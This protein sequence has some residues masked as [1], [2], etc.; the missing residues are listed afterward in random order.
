M[1]QGTKGEMQEAM[2]RTPIATAIFA[3]L[4]LWACLNC[5][6][7]QSAPSDEV[8]TWVARNCGEVTEEAFASRR[9]D[10]EV[11]TTEAPLVELLVGGEFTP[12]KLVLIGTLPE[13]LRAISIESPAKPLCEQLIDLK[14]SNQSLT[15]EQA[16]SLVQLKVK[17]HALAK[18]P[19]LKALYRS[20]SQLEASL[21]P[22]DNIYFPG[23]SVILSV[24]STHEKVHIEFTAPDPAADSSAYSGYPEASQPEI[25]EWALAVLEALE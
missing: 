21:K 10:F 8:L 12:E 7:A 1:V 4:G 5:F 11:P 17:V 16:V 24:T 2:R 9:P 6:H 13:G 19:K 22:A 18:N 3:G 25:L 14:T 23:F 20:V 15:A